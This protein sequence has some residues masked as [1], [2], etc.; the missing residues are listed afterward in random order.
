MDWL[1]NIIN[2][3]NGLFVLLFTIIIFFI[4]IILVKKG[5]LSFQGKGV[6]LG[7]QNKERV[8]L[9]RQTTYIH[10]QVDAIANKLNKQHPTFDKYRTFYICKCIEIEMIRSIHYNHIEDSDGYIDDRFVQLL[11]IIQKKAEDDF[12]FTKEFEMFLR[13]IIQGWVRQ[14]VRIRQ[15]G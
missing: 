10:T 15:K 6:S 2:G 13:D 9:Q 8:I 12:F 3:S 14:L 7:I 11:A 1:T 4:G 5:I